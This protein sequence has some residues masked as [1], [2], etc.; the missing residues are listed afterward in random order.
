MPYA[1]GTASAFNS[2][3][4]RL[5]AH[6]DLLAVQYPG[7]QDR[8]GE[9]CVDD[10]H[11]LAD[12]V[13]EALRQVDDRP[14]A[15]F[16]HSMGASVAYEV[17]VRLQSGRGPSVATL[18]VSGRQPPPRPDGPP[19]HLDDAAVEAEFRRYGWID[20]SIMDDQGLRS[21]VLPS[22]VAD[23]RAA[24]AYSRE[25]VV[26]LPIELVAYAGTTDPGAALTD[27]LGWSE[28]TSVGASFQYFEGD[29]FYL[30][31]REA[32]LIADMVRRLPG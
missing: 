17:A 22:L 25:D 11:T 10:V 32:E 15:L 30:V 21:L 1:G 27:L 4:E 6:V 16:G 29:H 9:P 18:F 24:L 19:E 8:L 13:A 14:M 5:P 28:F 23:Y 26:R 7:R 3:G 12:N 20:P 2:W 31:E